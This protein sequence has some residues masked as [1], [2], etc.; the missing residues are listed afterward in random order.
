M[1]SKS[2]FSVTNDQQ[3]QQLRRKR[4]AWE[5]EMERKVS[6]LQQQLAETTR[7]L[8]RFTAVVADIRLEMNDAKTSVREVSTVLSAKEERLC[9]D[10]DEA[11]RWST[12][13]ARNGS[14]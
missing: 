4:E 5:H 3:S 7:L 11:H 8:N 12:G 10:R 6:V 1:S 13:T 9:V 14:S 2:S